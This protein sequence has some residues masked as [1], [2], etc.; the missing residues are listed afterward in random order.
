MTLVGFM[1]ECNKENCVFGTRAV[2]WYPA[3]YYTFSSRIMCPYLEPVSKG[4][5]GSGAEKRQVGQG[6]RGQ[7]S[8]KAAMALRCFNV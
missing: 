8:S 2:R 7:P 4:Q 3:L 1:N 5:A 6:F